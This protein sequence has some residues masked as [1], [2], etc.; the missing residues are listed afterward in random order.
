MNIHRH[1]SV[2]LVTLV[3]AGGLWAGVAS[4]KVAPLEPKPASTTGTSPVAGQQSATT[5]T[6]AAGLLLQRSRIAHMQRV[7]A[8]R[9]AAEARARHGSRV[10]VTASKVTPATASNSPSGS[11]D[12]TEIPVLAVTAL[13]GLALGAA[14]SS[15][16]RRLRHRHGVPA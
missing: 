15:A 13:A 7:A 2:S 8:D 1:L 6:G 14:G 11:G 5:D 10:T 3:A 9:A 4:A 12:G 16:S